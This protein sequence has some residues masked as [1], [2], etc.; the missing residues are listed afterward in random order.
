MT[1]L[2]RTK[3]TLVMGFITGAVIV[4]L[5]TRL[6]YL[7]L[8]RGTHYAK[9]Q[10]Q[11]VVRLLPIR[12]PRGNI[13]DS[14]G[15]VVATN[16][17]AWSVYYD[18]TKPLT[19]KEYQ[20]LS[21]D[22][23]VKVSAL[24]KRIK[25]L[26][27]Q[28]PGYMPIRLK[29]N[30]SL[31]AFTLIEK[32]R[33]ELPGIRVQAEP[34]RYY[35]YNTIGGNILGYVGH[36]T[37]HQYKNRKKLGYSPNSIVGQSGVEY[38]YQKYLRGKNGTIEAKVN[39]LGQLVK[40]YA[41]KSPVPG[42]TVHLTINW[43][44]ETTAQKA[45]QFVEKS[46]RHT[47]GALGSP[48][49]R[50]GAVVVMNVH[51]GAIL[52][53]ASNPS[54]NPN[55]FVGGI[56]QTYYN[57]YF[58]V[59]N[60]AVE[61]AMNY[62]ISGLYSPGSIFKPIMAL[63][64]LAAGVISPSTTI[65]DPGY[66]KIDP[67]FTNWYKPGFG[68]VN[69]ARAIELSDDTFFYWVGYW[70][71]LSRMQTV[72]RDF[73]LNQKTN[74]DLPGEVRSLIPTKSRLKAAEGIPW[75]WGQDLNTAIGQGIDQFT[76]IALL[77]AIS[78]I[79]NGGTLYWPHVVSYITNSQ[80]KV[81]MRNHAKIQGHISASQADYQAVHLG[82]EWSAQKPRGTGY[83]AMANIPIHVATKTGTAEV[84]P[85]NSAYNA[86]FVTYAPMPNPQIAIIV[87]VHRGA[88][89]ANSGWVARAIYDQYFHLQDPLATKTYDTHFGTNVKWPFGW[90]SK[91]SKTKPV[92]KT[93]SQSTSTTKK[94]TAKA[95]TPAG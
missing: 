73:G 15:R 12:A 44:L 33:A 11:D 81:I 7:E 62:A 75:T 34:V 45:L 25:T 70:M 58:R 22:L 77:R 19:T 41:T 53:M 92:T 38:S 54:Y 56:S 76:P 18:R 55:R 80:G 5:G 91:S 66:F 90:Q 1:Q 74:I 69:V 57:K 36:I 40:E 78:A 93:N 37:A 64:A 10:N 8:E 61:P 84:P 39:R 88:W 63:G 13:V 85:L 4:A 82:M 67:Q 83:G 6:A 72:M 59:K 51:T 31:K 89:G 68:W 60:P 24:Q 26:N 46:I 3:K 43:H 94:K 14:S 50:A 65:F 48:R 2:E 9:M 49:A 20:L 28:L 79:A 86:F 16:K 17:T 23:G 27:V 29:S 30:L 52:A 42:N 21:I 71:H 35:P 47:S 87:Y 32:A 95:S